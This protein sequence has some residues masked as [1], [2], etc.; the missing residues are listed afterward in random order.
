MT[1]TVEYITKP[2]DRWDLIAHKAYGDAKA[3]DI[4]I[5]AN[6]GVPIAPEL[7]PG[8]VINVPIQAAATIDVTLLPPWK[9]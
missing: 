8:T 4:L 6:P 1:N 2:G 9:R 5:E 7:A 3:I